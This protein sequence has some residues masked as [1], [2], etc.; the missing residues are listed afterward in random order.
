MILGRLG[1]GYCKKNRVLEF[2][3][4]IFVKVASAPLSLGAP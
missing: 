4:K 2:L 1:N 3:A